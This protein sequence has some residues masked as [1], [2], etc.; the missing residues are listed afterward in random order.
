L[1]YC[2]LKCAF[3]VTDLKHHLVNAITLLAEYAVAGNRW[4]FETL[5]TGTDLARAIWHVLNFFEKLKTHHVVVLAQVVDCE[6]LYFRNFD[7]IQVH[8]E[9]LHFSVRFLSRFLLVAQYKVE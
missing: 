5:L 6:N 7:S 2:F 1:Q 4:A 3:C 9:C 8:H